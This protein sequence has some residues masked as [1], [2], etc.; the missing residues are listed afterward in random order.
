MKHGAA[1]RVL[2]LGDDR[3]GIRA[4]GPIPGEALFKAWIRSFQ[5][6]YLYVVPDALRSDVTD[7]FQK[8]ECKKIG[9]PENRSTS[10]LDDWFDTSSYDWAQVHR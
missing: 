9:K 10:Y 4:L 1:V 6:G 3:F 5:C 8:H 7:F 2:D